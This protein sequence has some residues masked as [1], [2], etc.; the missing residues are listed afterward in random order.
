[1]PTN[2][3]PLTPPGSCSPSLTEDNPDPD[4]SD[5]TD[6]SITLAKQVVQ[7]QA[8]D[9]ESQSPVHTH[10][11][12]ENKGQSDPGLTLTSHLRFESETP[13]NGPQT[14]SKYKQTQL[15]DAFTKQP[16]KQTPKR[17][18]NGPKPQLPSEYT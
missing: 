13:Y 17:L 5:V 14:R 2:S 3:Q 6:D 8:E 4:T 11:K 18:D 15:T 12:E 7:A 1:M 16:N 10:P 9:I